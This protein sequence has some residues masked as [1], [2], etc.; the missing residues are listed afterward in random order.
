MSAL[1][2]DVRIVSPQANQI[3][4][5]TGTR[6]ENVNFPYFISSLQECNDVAISSPTDTQILRFNSSTLRW[7][8]ADLVTQLSAL[9]DVSISN[10]S[11]NQVIAFTTSFS[12]NKWTSYTTSGLIFDD[13][14]KKYHSF[15]NYERTICS[16]K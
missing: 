15:R 4:R 16:S 1:T 5:Y 12:L 14:D 7:Q 8:N 3:L 13:I 2:T 10:P 9:T 11:N 6:W